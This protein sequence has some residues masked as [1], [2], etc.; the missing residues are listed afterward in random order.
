MV[1][2]FAKDNGY[3]KVK[4]AGKWRGYQVYIPLYE[5]DYSCIGLP[6]IILVKGNKIRLSTPEE[7][8]DYMDDSQ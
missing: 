5:V 7:A 6:L 4:K 8:F 3:C 1:L 2:Q